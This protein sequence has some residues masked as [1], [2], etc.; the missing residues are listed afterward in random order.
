M[1]DLSITNTFIRVYLMYKLNCEVS[2]KSLT[3]KKS[4]L[5][6]IYPIKYFSNICNKY[7]KCYC[8]YLY[9]VKLPW[10]LIYQQ[11]IFIGIMVQVIYINLLKHYNLFI[12]YLSFCMNI[13]KITI[14]E[15]GL[16]AKFIRYFDSKQ[17]I[18]IFQ[19]NLETHL[20][21]KLFQ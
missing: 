20:S 18:L 11:L 14:K 16:D 15:L 19:S 3:Y 5:N 21:L 4:Q 10:Y 8:C 12:L 1:T 13:I 2:F 9:T 17:I 7:M 6:F